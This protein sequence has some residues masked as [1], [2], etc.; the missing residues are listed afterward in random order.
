MGADP[1]RP[2]ALA[3]LHLEPQLA[4]VDDLTQRGAHLAARA[5]RGRG[6]VLH[7]D[8]EAHRRLS[9][10]EV[11][12]GEHRRVPFHHRDHPRRRPH[13][14]ADRAADVRDQAVLDHELVH[15]LEPR[16]RS[17]GGPLA[18]R[19]RVLERFGPGPPV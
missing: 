15:P 17:L 6:D 13:P 16:P 12:V 11:L 2:L 9:F 7:A 10:G 19:H 18:R 4:A 14:D 8:L 1:D 3:D 5:L